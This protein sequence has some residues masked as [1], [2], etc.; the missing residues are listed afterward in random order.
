MS[1]AGRTAHH[2][3]AFGLRLAVA[4]AYVCA[5]LGLALWA[6]NAWPPADASGIWFYS[7]ALVGPSERLHRRTLLHLTARGA[8]KWC[9]THPSRTHRQPKFLDRRPSRRGYRPSRSDRGGGSVRVV[10]DPPS[11]ASTASF[12]ASTSCGL[13]F[14][15]ASG[16]GYVLYGIVYVSSVYAAF[17]AD[18]DRLTALLLA[19]LVFTW[20]P[21]ERLGRI[22]Q[23]ALDEKSHACN[24]SRDHGGPRN[25]DRNRAAW[26]PSVC[27][28]HAPDNLQRRH[29]SSS[30]RHADGHPATDPCAL[31]GDCADSGR[32]QTGTRTSDA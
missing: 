12:S 24:P 2:G 1:S 11:D 28:R 19:A 26:T 4:L 20:G 18:P 23:H 16:S 13:R 6:H 5:L 22:A 9:C 25:C 15:A 10:G 14:P 29:G 27:G 31:S 8:C 30:R 7:A 21:L 17:A 32:N 3:L